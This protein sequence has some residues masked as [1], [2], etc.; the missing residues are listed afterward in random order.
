MSQ[1]INF[2]KF[3]LPKELSRTPLLNCMLSLQYIIAKDTSNLSGFI[4]AIFW[5]SENMDKFRSFPV[6]FK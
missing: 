4:S 1:I 2:E 3:T 6:H 5:N